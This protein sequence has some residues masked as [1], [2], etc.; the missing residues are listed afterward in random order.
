LPFVIVV[1][2]VLVGGLVSVLLLHT[3][4]AQY[5]FRITGMQSRLTTL[6][7][8]AQ[9]QSQVVAADS[10]PIA[11]Q[12]RAAALGMVPTSITAFHRR[13]DGRAVAVQTPVYVAPSIAAGTL[14]APKTPPPTTSPT[15]SASAKSGTS[16]T[17]PTSSAS[18]KPSGKAPAAGKQSTTK[19]SPKHHK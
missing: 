7:D 10:S 5:A 19:Q 1:G 11:L 15:S 8:E 18:G 13:V 12:H 3:L 14:A 17:S 4:A 9:Q 2:A 16:G 6:T